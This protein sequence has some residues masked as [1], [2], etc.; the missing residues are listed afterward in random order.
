[1]QAKQGLS[2]RELPKPNPSRGDQLVHGQGSPHHRCR[3]GQQIR[4]DHDA[5]QHSQSEQRHHSQA[6]LKQAQAEHDMQRQR[7]NLRLRLWR[8]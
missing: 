3:D 7:L 4:V 8:S 5:V 1:M 2:I 6:H